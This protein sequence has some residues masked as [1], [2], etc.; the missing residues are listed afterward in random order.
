[1]RSWLSQKARVL[2]RAAPAALL[3]ATL[4]SAPSFAG[5]ELG[6]DAAIS[7]VR[8]SNVDAV[9]VVASPVSRAVIDAMQAE[10]ARIWTP[11]GVHV[12]WQTPGPPIDS[13][14]TVVVLVSP[15]LT[16][17]GPARAEGDV[18]LGCFHEQ[19]GRAQALIVVLPNQVRRVVNIQVAQHLCRRCFEGSL[20][21]LAGTLLGRTFAHELG[22]YLLG[23]EHSATGLMRERFP[24]DELF[25]HKPD[26]LVPTDVQL[27][28]LRE[29]RNAKPA[30]EPKTPHQR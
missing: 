26:R 3:S 16:R 23:P 6:N 5:D 7:L 8:T 25:T 28:L 17:C 11:L 21:H 13:T 2:R 19:S 20:E 15:E 14:T 30:L 27:D 9:L 4:T 1:M 24:P 12:R 18:P 29:G 10:A 22:H